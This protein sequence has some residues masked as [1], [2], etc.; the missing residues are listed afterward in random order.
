MAKYLV[1][2]EE[3]KNCYSCDMWVVYGCDQ[4]EYECIL[5]DDIDCWSFENSKTEIHKDCPLKKVE[6]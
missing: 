4:D 1:E 2:I 5:D 6:E 3:V